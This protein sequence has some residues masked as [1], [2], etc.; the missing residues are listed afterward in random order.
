MYTAWEH[1]VISLRE[2]VVPDYMPFGLQ[3]QSLAD[4]F[5]DDGRELAATVEGEGDDVF[6]AFKRPKDA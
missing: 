1:K 6:L 2:A 4:R 3:L 5:G